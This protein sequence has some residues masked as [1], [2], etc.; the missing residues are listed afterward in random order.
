M[1]ILFDKVYW[2]WLCSLTQKREPVEINP[3]LRICSNCGRTFEFN[4]KD[5]IK[6]LKNDK[7]IVTCPNCFYQQAY[8]LIYHVTLVNDDK[9]IENNK[10]LRRRGFK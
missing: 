9:T 10:R 2:D 5:L 7:L 3:R 6:M 1:I 4:K 8:K